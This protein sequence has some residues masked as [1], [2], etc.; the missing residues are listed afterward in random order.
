VVR[1]LLRAQSETAKRFARTQISNIQRR[2]ESCI[3]VL[4]PAVRLLQG[5]MRVVANP[6]VL[7][8]LSR[9]GAILLRQP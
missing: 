2:M 6:P 9:R 1:G 7:P 8:M 5:W 3:W 4:P